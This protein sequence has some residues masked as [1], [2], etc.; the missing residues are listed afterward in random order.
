MQVPNGL[1]EIIATFG[2]IDD[3]DFVKNN[4]VQ[5]DLPYPLLYGNTFVYHTQAHKLAVP[6]FQN[7]FNAIADAGLQDR[8]RHYGG[9]YAP[10]GIRGHISHPSTHSWGIAIDIN[11]LT[12]PLGKHGDMDPQVIDLFKA[13]GFVWGGNFKSRLDG[14]HF[15]LAQSY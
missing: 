9:I 12:N 1:D 14:M 15:Q 10:R 6:I 2:S 8:A 5:F 13:H 7:V 4:I 11:P 3:P